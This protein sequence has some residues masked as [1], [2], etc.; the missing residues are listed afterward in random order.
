M[1]VV[2]DRIRIPFREVAFR[3]VR[4]SGPG[5]QNVNKVSSKAVLRWPAAS[6]SSLPVD[7][8]GRFLERFGP[9]ITAT[10][11]IV[12]SCDRHRDR[13]RNRKDCLERL[14]EMLVLVAT[15]PTP[16]RRTRASR[17]SVER[18]LESKR[19]RAER[20]RLRGRVD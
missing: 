10:G 6:S 4:S 14:R 19:I 16:R 17:G 15:A 18:R 13:E 5:G 8:R 3:F 7:V 12:L 20:K 2:S 9:R 11:E 1:L